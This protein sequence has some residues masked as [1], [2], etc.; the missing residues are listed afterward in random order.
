MPKEQIRKRG[1]RKPKE[2]RDTQPS[3]LINDFTDAA[4]PDADE[5]N[6]AGPSS[7]IHPARAAML[8]GQRPHPS[9]QQQAP[10]Y[11]SQEVEQTLEWGRDLRAA[12][13]PFGELD[14]DLKGYFR[15]VDDQIRDWEGVPSAGEERE[16]EGFSLLAF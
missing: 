16:G 13:Y 1:K 7:G 6:E 3:G 2:S 4:V 14:P 11:Q 10:A 8:A 5:H 15:T 12:E 9:H